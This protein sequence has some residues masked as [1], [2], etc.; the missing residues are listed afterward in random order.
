MRNDNLYYIMTSFSENQNA[1]PHLILFLK[2]ALD[3]EISDFSKMSLI[4]FIL[5]YPVFF[6]EHCL[7]P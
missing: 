5:V 1:S 2:I 6:L 3:S 4:L 7:I